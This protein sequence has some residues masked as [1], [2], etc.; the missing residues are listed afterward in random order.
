MPWAIPLFDHLVEFSGASHIGRVRGT[1]E[2]LWWA[3]PRLG[4]FVVADGMG[5]HAAGDVA[6]RVAVEELG[7]SVQ[8]PE[9]TRLFEDYARSPTLEKRR[10]VFEALEAA[11]DRAHAAVRE[12][13]ARDARQRGMGCTLD[14]ALLLGN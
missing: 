3:D 7:R 6:A 9:R 8:S 10:A 14:A 5:G 12:T 1:N 2:D 4:L 13:A 11:A